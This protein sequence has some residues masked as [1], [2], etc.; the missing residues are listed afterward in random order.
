MTVHTLYYQVEWNPSGSSWVDITSY[1]MSVEGDFQTSGTGNGI[2]F[3]DSSDAT[4]KITVDPTAHGGSL[5]LATWAYVPIRVT[6]TANANTARGAAGVILE[7]QQDADKAVFSVVGYK[8]LISTVRAYSQLLRSRPLAT[9]TTATSI[10][11]PA[12]GGYAAGLLNWIM[13]QAGGRPYEQAG[14]YSGA[15]FYYSLAQ[16]PI[17][18]AYS[19]VAGEDGWLEALRCV[20]AT[21]GQLYQRPDGVIC[22]VSPL[23]IAGGSSVWTLTSASYASVERRSTAR[24]VVSSFNCTY[25]PRV[26][27][28][29]TEIISDTNVRVVAVGATITVELEPQYPFTS[30]QTASGG[31]QLLADAISA[32]C[33]DGTIP[34]QGSGYTHTLS[35]SAQHITLTITNAG[36]LPFVIEK[37]TLRGTPLV[38]TEAGTVTLGSGNPTQSIEDNPLIQS[39]SHAQRLARMAL[40]FYGTARP[41]ITASGV[42]YDP[43]I[44]QVG[45]CGTITVSAWG[46]SAAPAVILGVKHSESGLDCDLDV[47]VTTGLPTLSQYFL[48]QTASQVATKKIGY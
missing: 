27:A 6:F 21:G 18:P 1:V 10:E 44:H 4:A 39:R 45:L 23:T 40:A 20:R 3:G 28:G 9:K 41:I 48:V 24:D 42:R 11:N 35:Y 15:A 2:G 22:Y 32:T 30:L 36:A 47:V 17:A 14:S 33:Y 8:Q 7:M 37:I 5:S 29:M 26:V 25:V 12:T 31:T 16:A 34:A 19:W 13:W 38:P 46:L 43:T